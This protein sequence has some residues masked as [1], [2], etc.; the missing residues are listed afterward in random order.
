MTQS[1]VSC[2]TSINTHNLRHTHI[3]S[4]LSKTFIHFNQ[5]VFVV[6]KKKWCLQC[7]YG[8]NTN[9]NMHICIT[10][11]IKKISFS[12]CIFISFGPRN[13]VANNYG[14]MLSLIGQ[15]IKCHCFML[16]LN[17]CVESSNRTIVRGSWLCSSN[18]THT[19][20]D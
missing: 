4:P 15:C 17:A 16:S 18:R 19:L 8:N 10:W 13:I 5:F 1:N 12:L 11:S 3:I 14:L 2:N 7:C 20:Q 9:T 6:L